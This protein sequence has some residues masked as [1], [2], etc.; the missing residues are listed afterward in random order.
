VLGQ[1]NQGLLL[2]VLT[3]VRAAGRLTGCRQDPQRRTAVPVQDVRALEG[4]MKVQ[5]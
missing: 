4:V 3:A 2:R 5:N 1:L